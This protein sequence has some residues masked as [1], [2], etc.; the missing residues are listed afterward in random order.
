MGP[1]AG[2]ARLAR[3]L[4]TTDS[5]RPESWAASAMYWS[6]KG[7]STRALDHAERALRADDR[8][9]GALLVKGHVCLSLRRADA[10]ASAFRRATALAP[11][12]VSYAGLVAATSSSAG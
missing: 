6:S 1:S 2:L 7:D 9:A 8:H 4:S 11:S 3:D 5:D 10:A 12:V